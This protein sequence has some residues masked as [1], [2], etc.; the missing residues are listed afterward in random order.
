[1]RI[2]PGTAGLALNLEAAF[3]TGVIGPGER[4]WGGKD[5]DSEEDA[6][7]AKRSKRN[8]HDSFPPSCGRNRQNTPKVQRAESNHTPKPV[9]Y[10]RNTP[11]LQLWSK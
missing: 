7:D 2:D 5:G 8:S 3:V 11:L 6:E 10:E 9:V 4:E 1:L